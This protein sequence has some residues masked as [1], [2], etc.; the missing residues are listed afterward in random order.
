[1]PSERFDAI[2]RRDLDR[3]PG[4]AEDEWVPRARRSTV[5][6]SVGHAVAAL[7]VVLLAIGIG[8]SLEAIR[9]SQLA[10]DGG[11]ATSDEPFFIVAEQGAAATPSTSPM[12]ALAGPPVCPPGQLPWLAI[13]HPPPPGTVPGTGAASP[14]AAFRRAQPTVSEFTMFAWG[15]SQPLSGPNDPRVHTGPVWIVAASGE[16]Y[17]AMAPGAA[18]AKN[19][20]FAY[21]AK[22]M[23]CRTPPSDRPRPSPT[24][25]PVG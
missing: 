6:M 10:D 13:T 22:F 18:D 23:G 8:V 9:N 1:M 25:G 11:A 17:I 4:L 15:D 5:R 3:L 7:A 24:T 21:P 2:F 14:E 16:T 20:W 19:N 12:P